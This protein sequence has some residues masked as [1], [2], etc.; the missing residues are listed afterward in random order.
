VIVLEE[1][2]E[3]KEEEKDDKKIPVIVVKKE[4]EEKT[5][6]SILEDLLE[7]AD[8]DGK[9]DVEV[10]FECLEKTGIT[11]D[12]LIACG[13]VDIAPV[14]EPE[15]EPEAPAPVKNVHPIVYKKT[16][17]EE[18]PEETKETPVV[19]KKVVVEEEPEEIPVASKKYEKEP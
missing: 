18:E 16:V 12:D 5:C 19:Y 7:C 15:P 14:P 9:D 17:E 8:A 6:D 4:G 10:P 3:E 1:E 13:Y 2:E 11:I